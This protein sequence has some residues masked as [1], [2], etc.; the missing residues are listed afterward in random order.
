MLFMFVLSIGFC[1][2]EREGLLYL[3]ALVSKALGGVPVLGFQDCTF[4]TQDRC[5]FCVLLRE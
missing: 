1:D 5:T 2:S 3:L 4:G